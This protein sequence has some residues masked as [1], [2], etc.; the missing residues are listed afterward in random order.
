[1]KEVQQRLLQQE[2]QQRNLQ[3]ANKEIGATYKRINVAT[4][5]PIRD[6]NPRRYGTDK[7]VEATWR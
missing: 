1:M 5:N 7:P 2:V 3:H 6:R 4:S